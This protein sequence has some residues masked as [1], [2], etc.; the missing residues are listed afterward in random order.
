MGTGEEAEGR[1]GLSSG[2]GRRHTRP[3]V[4]LSEADVRIAAFNPSVGN[5][6]GRVVTGAVVPRTRSP[7]QGRRVRPSWP[8]TSSCGGRNID[9]D[10]GP[11]HISFQGLPGRGPTA[12]G[13]ARSKT[14][15]VKAVR[16]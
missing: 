16:A 11:W 8:R 14:W 13:C 2:K 3:K 15:V 7:R 9:G 1:Q 10:R 6:H 12:A 5:F 4:C